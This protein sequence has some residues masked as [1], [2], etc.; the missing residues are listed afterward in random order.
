[1]QMRDD[2]RRELLAALERDFRFKPR[3]GDWLQGGT[4]PQCGK[5]EVF[6][7]ADNPRIIKCGRVERCGWDAAAKDLYP[8]IFDTFS[9]RYKRTEA[10]PHA[11]ADAYLAHARGL[12][13][14]GLRGAYTQEY[15]HDDG[16]NIGSATVRFPLPG[17]GWWERLIDQPSRFDRKA[18]FA[19]GKTYRGQWWQRPDVTLADLAGASEIW[20]NEGIFDALSLEQA[21]QRAVSIMSC[22]NYPAEALKALRIAIANGPTPGKSPKLI[23]ALDLGKAGTD[24]TREFVERARDEG[25]ICGAAQVLEDGEDGKKLDWNDLLQRDRLGETWRE[26]FL[27]NG[28]VLIA[29]SAVEK[30]LLIHDRHKVRSFHFVFKTE[31]YWASYDSA[32]VDQQVAEAMATR[33]KHLE[34]LDAAELAKIREEATRAALSIEA[35]ANCAFRVLYRQRDEAT[36]ETSYFLNIDFPSD[37]P[38]VKGGFSATALMTAAEFKKRLFAIGTGAI[39]TGSQGQLDR[40]MQRQT[41]RIADVQ[42]LGFTGYCRDTGAYVF[43][44]IAVKDGRVYRPNDDDYFDM[45]KLALKLGTSERLL[46]IHYDPDTCDTSWL[47]DLLTAFGPK[48]LVVLAFFFG[49]LFAEQVR[50]ERKSFPFLEMFGLPGSGKTTLVEFL[51]KL[52]GREN[53]EGFDPA[54]ATAAAMARNLGKVGNLPVVLIEGDRADDTSHA[55]KFDWEELKTAYNGR[56]VRARGVKS[57]GMETFEP[58]FRGAVIIEQNEPVNASRAILERIMSLGFD[59][60][61]WGDHTKNAAQRLE[62][63]P[64]EKVSGFIVHAARRETEILNRFRQAFAMH[65]QALLA[66]PEIRVNRLAKTHGQ[67]LAMLDALRVMLPELRDDQHADA[68]ELIRAMAVQRQRAVENEHPDVAT[69]WERFDY[70]QEIEAPATE[71]P[72][73]HSRDP[74]LIAVSLSEF[75][76]R[77][78]ERRLEIPSHADLVRNLKTSKHRRFAGTRTVNSIAGA[79]RGTTIS[80]HCWVFERPGAAPSK[81]A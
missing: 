26:R 67:L 15:Y 73:N 9:K 54:K 75:E 41:P 68:A 5:K 27:W 57:A 43:G 24:K 23:W 20:I 80:K 29:A 48:G 18:R 81:P 49:S 61:G 65:E 31:T 64:V 14:M 16:R 44:D 8:E 33:K 60:E 6:T 13:L 39:W 12:D 47:P 77:C 2:I 71:H 30:A 58:P 76:Q 74:K 25:W 78:G 11:A 3:R 35:I 69:F 10:D 62:Q 4:C 7:R 59:M 53:Y 56:T 21:G 72:I 66:L 46:D 32:S 70:L 55:R 79:N 19:P 51:W 36:D 22:Y 40:I 17:G 34:E 42:P 63:W 52:L 37:R 38:S 50:R 1:M 28:D 45:G